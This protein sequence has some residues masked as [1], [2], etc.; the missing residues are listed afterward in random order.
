MLRS[1]AAASWSR[2]DGSIGGAGP[3]RRRRCACWYP[4]WVP[5]DR[6]RRVPAWR[7]APRCLAAAARRRGLPPSGAALVRAA[8]HPAAGLIRSRSVWWP[9]GVTGA[10]WP[11]PPESPPVHGARDDARMGRV[12]AGHPASDAC[13]PAPVRRPAAVMERRGARLRRRGQ[14]R[15]VGRSARPRP[16]R[17][18]LDRRALTRVGAGWAAVRTPA[19]GRGSARALQ[20][21]AGGL[22][23]CQVAQVR[24]GGHGH[25]ARHAP[26]CLERVHDRREPPGVD[27]VMRAGVSRARRAVWW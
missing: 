15:D 14:W 26:P 12:A 18:G 24:R 23:A 7:E 5:P 27:L 1:C 25:G 4:W 17:P 6:L 11:S 9:D 2:S 21:W 3:S 16:L 10:L 20:P 13:T 22:A 19:G 8:W